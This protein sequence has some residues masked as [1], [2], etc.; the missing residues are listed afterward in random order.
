[1]FPMYWIYDIPNWLLFLLLLA[2]FGTVSLSGLHLTR[3]FV[4]RVVD[5]SGR[6]NDVT[7]YCF[8]A[9]GVLY[10]L[11]LGLIAVG[12]WQNFNDADSK[13]AREANSL[14]ALYRDL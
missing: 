14:G 4:R 10:G 12:T 13:A 1:M 9:V 11:T 6:H 7:S 3:P 8:A 2:F 5:A